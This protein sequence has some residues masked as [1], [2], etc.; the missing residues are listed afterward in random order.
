MELNARCYIA[1][2]LI[3][4][5][6]QK[7]HLCLSA[8]VYVCFHQVVLA[9]SYATAVVILVPCTGRRYGVIAVMGRETVIR[10]RALMPYMDRW[11]DMVT[12]FCESARYE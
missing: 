5:A 7:K 6:V 2:L 10:E 9:D 3:N 11:K 12:C 1:L 8:D 4:N